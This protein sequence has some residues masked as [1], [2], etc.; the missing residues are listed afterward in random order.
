MIIEFLWDLTNRALE[1]LREVLFTVTLANLYAAV[2]ELQD[3]LRRF[4][5]L[6]EV[7]ALTAVAS[8]ARPDL[9]SAIERVASW[10]KLSGNNEYQDYDLRISYEAGL[11][12]VRSYYSH[13][14]I[15]SDFNSPQLMMA[16]RTLPFFARLFS[17]LLDNSAFHS[18]LSSGRLNL[19][20]EASVIDGLL[21]ISV[22]NNLSAA[23]DL[24]HVS[25]Q[26]ARVNSEFGRE[27][28]SKLIREEGGSGYPKIW[29]I[30]AHDL[31][32]DHAVQVSL[33]SENDFLVEIML[34]AKGIV[35]CGS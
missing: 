23:V 8:L 3:S 11:E 16:G 6:E 35:L 10:F 14:N 7:S 1:S 2:D 18:G 31:G 20:G 26:V 4:S 15:V 9:H 34:D 33:T 5:Y 28:A 29:K 19:R 22:R 21:H 32:G 24:D 13:L 17:I 27:R 12:T 30:L 25:R